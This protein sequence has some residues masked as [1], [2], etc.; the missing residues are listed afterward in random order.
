MKQTTQS[1]W[2]TLVAL[3]LALPTAYFIIIAI[4]KYELGVHG[5]FD[6]IA[7]FLESV[8]IKET[9]GWNIN[10]LI[11]FGPVIAFLL[12]LFQ[13]LK[14]DWDFTKEQ[15]FFH[16]TI[17]KKWFPLLVVAFSCSLLAFLL[18]YMVGEN[19]RC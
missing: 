9:I 18:I 8:G 3:L 2:L 17:R 6:A 13:V 5:P 1:R 10:L 4:L 19:C 7:P 12:A 15:F 14:I 11:L 16:F